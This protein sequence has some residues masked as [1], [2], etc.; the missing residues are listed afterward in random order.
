MYYCYLDNSSL[1][2]F[3]NDGTGFVHRVADSGEREN[4]FFEFYGRVYTN[5][6]D[7]DGLKWDWI[8]NGGLD[9]NVANI[10]V[11]EAH[12]RPSYFYETTIH[13]TATILTLSD[14]RKTVIYERE[15]DNIG[16]SAT[17]VIRTFDKVTEEDVFGWFDCE[18]RC[19]YELNNP[20][21]CT[22]KHS[23]ELTH[24]LL[25]TFSRVV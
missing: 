15:Q 16:H 22:W 12:Y 3:A 13:Y 7:E 19:D 24:E 23:I 20:D 9:S 5:Q 18:C 17:T 4:N 25:K 10:E 6:L 14:G 8:G 21:H 11:Y 2:V 1:V